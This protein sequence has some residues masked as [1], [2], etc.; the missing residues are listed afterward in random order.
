MTHD[1]AGRVILGEMK[2]RDQKLHDDPR[3]V[4][5]EFS[6]G[7]KYSFIRLIRSASAASDSGGPARL[8]KFSNRRT[9]S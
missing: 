7:P 3:D 2:E 8:L 4:E 6:G 1:L 9:E 5:A